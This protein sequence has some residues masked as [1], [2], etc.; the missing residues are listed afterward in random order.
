[1]LTSESSIENRTLRG[2]EI[3]VRH[4]YPLIIAAVLM[5]TLI[6]WLNSIIH[7]QG[8]SFVTISGVATSGDD[9]Y[10]QGLSRYG[11]TGGITG[12]PRHIS[13]ADHRAK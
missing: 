1:L 8:V 7:A 3:R 2:G 6:T 9:D 11:I 10:V 12:M 5:L 4:L 13:A